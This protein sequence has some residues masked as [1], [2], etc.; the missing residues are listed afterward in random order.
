MLPS[1]ST[2]WIL[3]DQLGPTHPA[4]AA[5]DPKRDQILMVE[6]RQRARQLRYHQQKL[7]FVYA[8]MRHRA[9]ELRRD[10][11]E[12]DYR[13]LD[14]TETF[15]AGLEAHLR[16]YH[17]E[18]LVIM[19]PND[20]ATSQ[21]LPALVRD[22]GLPLKILPST[23][24]LTAREE[25]A[26]WAGQRRR[27]LME[28]HY[29]RLRRK[30][31]IL[32]DTTGEPIGGAWNFDAENRKPYKEFA[33]LPPQE[34]PRP[35]PQVPPDPITLGAIENV[36]RHFPGHPG[37]ASGLWLPTHRAGALQW[38]RHFIDE[39]LPG[40]GPW[41]DV[42]AAEEPAL[43]HSVLS[44]FLNIGLLTPAECVEAAVVAWE[45]GR[46]PLASVEGFIRQIIGWR[47]FVN[48][49]YWLRMP[50]YT[51]LNELGA[52]RPLPSWAY[53]G[54]TQMNCVGT[55]IRQALATGYNH[56]IQR[57]MILGNYFLLGGYRPSEVLRWYNELYLDAYDW[58]MAANVIGMVLHADGGF[59]ATKPYAAGPAYIHKM[60]N[61]CAG[62][63]Y[64][65]AAKTGPDACPFHALYWNFYV[66]HAARFSAN[67]RVAVITSACQ[68]KSPAER[69]ALQ[70][71][72]DTFLDRQ[73]VAAI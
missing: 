73:G 18:R 16:Q 14:E 8:A 68:K 5:G 66:R 36:E 51:E 30:L 6:S 42:M 33:K 39:R 53:T 60:S 37:R 23:M 57:L 49:V 10:G 67:P 40:F 20:H 58:V 32:M 4:L 38:L 31:G 43:F 12:V 59:M 19:A 3:G 22:A 2:L 7:A 17:P 26:S 61:Y 72:A 52:Q 25:F 24:F 44:P 56:H 28:Q 9:Q 21:T 46:A 71:A 35:L 34:R 70:Q 45:D 15:A 47:E 27:L 54:E 41:E 1:S 11:W 69:Q 13:T 50:G 48:G 55:T 29:R 63:R 64:Q 65:P 62:C